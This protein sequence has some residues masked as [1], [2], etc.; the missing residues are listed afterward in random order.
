MMDRWVAYFTTHGDPMV[1]PADMPIPGHRIADV[2]TAPD[3]YGRANAVLLAAAPELADQ[4]RESTDLLAGWM[5]D[6]PPVGLF[7]GAIPDETARAAVRDF[8][9][10]ARDLLLSVGAL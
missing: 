3:D 8:I 1:V 10:T 2:S 4:L 6:G 9:A 7:V 5:S